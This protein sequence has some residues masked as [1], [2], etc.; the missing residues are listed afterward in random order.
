MEHS[1][2]FRNYV[3]HLAVAKSDAMGNGATTAIRP[4]AG[5]AGDANGT[6]SDTKPSPVGPRPDGYV[7]GNE[8]FGKRMTSLPSS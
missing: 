3:R 6:V 4:E 7:L 2:H 1:S 8:D 5:L